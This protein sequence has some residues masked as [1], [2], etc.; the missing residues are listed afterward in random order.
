MKKVTK[1]DYI[2]SIIYVEWQSKKERKCVSVL[3]RM[4]ASW[5]LIQKNMT[6]QS[7]YKLPF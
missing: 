4:S 7:E 3:S 6:A 5:D 1:S 2:E